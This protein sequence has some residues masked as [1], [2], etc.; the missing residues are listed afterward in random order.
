ML[1]ITCIMRYM[2]LAVQS[3]YLYFCHNQDIHKLFPFFKFFAFE[4]PN[5]GG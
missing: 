1:V 3:V 2:Y 5:G 4:F